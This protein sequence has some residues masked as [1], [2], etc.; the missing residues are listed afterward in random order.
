MY[1]DKLP[2]PERILLL[3]FLALYMSPLEAQKKGYSEG[4]I[5]NLEGITI[6]GRVKDRSAEP[7]TDL[8]KKIR[9]RPEGT[10][11]RRKYGPHDI[12]A[13][14]Y[15]A[16]SFA[17]VPIREESDFFRFR[18]YVDEGYERSF[19]KVIS[20]SGPLTYYH[21]EYIDGESHY[22]D[23]VPLFHKAYSSEMVRVTQGILGLKRKKLAEYFSDCPDLVH[24]IE[25][26]ELNQI[27]EVFSYYLARCLDQN[28]EGRWR[29]LQVVQDGKDVTEEHNPYRE[30]YIIFSDDGTFETGGR[31][32]GSNTGRYTYV[33]EEGHLFLDSDAGAEDDS[34]WNVTIEGDTMQWQGMGSEWANGFRII[35]LRSDR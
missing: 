32:Y 23:Y 27:D 17:S 30:R 31:P 10:R 33:H 14:G 2:K 28:P 1:S 20:N 11:I 26:R 29:M 6:E 25:Y 7:F 5:V 4:Y 8:Y 3:L 35:H 15:G 9:F 19:L 18:Y 21:W 22:V 13:Y 24:A 34:R 12:L 16:S